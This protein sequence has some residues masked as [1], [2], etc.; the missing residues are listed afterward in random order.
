MENGKCSTINSPPPPAHV[1]SKAFFTGYR[2]RKIRL[3]DTFCS[4]DSHR[5]R[6]SPT[7]AAGKTHAF[8]NMSNKKADTPLRLGS[9]ESSGSNNGIVELMQPLITKTW[10]G[11]SLRPS[12]SI[13]TIPNLR[14]SETEP[15]HTDHTQIL[16]SDLGW[17]LLLQHV[18]EAHKWRR[19]PP[20]YTFTTIKQQ[21]NNIHLQASTE[22]ACNRARKHQ[23][24]SRQSDI[25]R[26]Q[27]QLSPQASQRRLVLAK[28]KYGGPVLGVETR[29]RRD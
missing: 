14:K 8:S 16:V 17:L 2:S 24:E 22:S 21:S 7:S 5:D 27:T 12:T 9:L 4:C 13:R 18:D 20:L 10:G 26:S 11:R 28:Q 19:P 29:R 6:D 23:R 25:Y 1:N 3:R 15:F